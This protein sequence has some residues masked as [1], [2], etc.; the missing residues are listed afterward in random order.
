MSTLA[1][2]G[3]D[4]QL[5]SPDFLDDPYPVYDRLRREAPVY[6]CAPW[7]CWILTRYADV[8]DALREDG[9]RLT[10]AGRI[11]KPLRR[12]PATAQT[13]L[14]ALEAHYAVGLLHSDPPDHT[15]LRGL[16]NKVFNPR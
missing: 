14:Q 9:R 6:W 7:D 13:E 12:L 15:R 10:V 5:L 16:V 11:Q 4:E 8:Q 1:T 3:L 2:P